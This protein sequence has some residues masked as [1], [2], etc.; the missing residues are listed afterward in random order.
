MLYD[1]KSKQKKI[2]LV[3]HHMADVNFFKNFVEELKNQGHKI[4]AVVRLR[5]RL[6]SVLKEELGVEP[7]VMGSHRKHLPAKIGGELI[8]LIKLYFL[9]RKEKI[10]ALYLFSGVLGGLAAKLAGIESI[11]FYDDYEYKMNFKIPAYTFDQ[12]YVPEIVKTRAE[13]TDKRIR[14]FKG[15]KEMAYLHPKYFN[16]IDKKTLLKKLFPSSNIERYAFIRLVDNKSLN[17]DQVLTT[18]QLSYLIKTCVNM[19]L[20]PL[21]NL[22]R[23]PEDI[24][25][26]AIVLKQ[27]PGKEHYSLMRHSDLIISNGETMVWEGALL[28][29]KSI[30]LNCRDMIITDYL[31]EKGSLRKA[32]EFSE[33]IRI[34]KDEKQ[35]KKF[36]EWEDVTGF[37]LK[38]LETV[39]ETKR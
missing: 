35:P 16:P 27:M 17:T 37:M 12:Y 10:D 13:I 5:G 6:L 4:I 28:G 33:A 15:L 23:V 31:E 32:K 24:P 26:E 7:I 18:E 9:I 8:R 14:S 39:S 22:E 21:L 11:N 29:V 30:A 1:N 36:E 20:T 25:K 38:T 3:I 34:M 2:L 19:G